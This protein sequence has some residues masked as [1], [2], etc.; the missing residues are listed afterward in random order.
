MSSSFVP[1]VLPTNEVAES[2]ANKGQTSKKKRSKNRKS[3]DNQLLNQGVVNQEDGMDTTGKLWEVDS[4]N[5]L[6]TIQGIDPIAH[7]TSSDVR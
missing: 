2:Q 5:L 3:P 6:E 7:F 4:S 1:L